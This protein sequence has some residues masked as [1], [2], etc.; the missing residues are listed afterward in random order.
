LEHPEDGCGRRPQLQ[1]RAAHLAGTRAQASSPQ[2]LKL[3]NRKR[4][5]EKVHNM[6]CPCLDPSVKAP[7]FTM[8]KKSHIQVRGPI[9]PGSPF[10]K[11]PGDIAMPHL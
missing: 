10:K 9:Q 4:F 6:L 5:V 3:S 8:D 7:M 11:G 2:D 1:Q